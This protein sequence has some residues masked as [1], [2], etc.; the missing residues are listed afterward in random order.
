M[1]LLQNRRKQFEQLTSPLGHELFR[2]AYWRLANKDDAEDVVQETYLRAFRSFHT[3][4]IGSN[5]K[6]WMTRIL[7]N[8]ISDTMK[9]R[10]RLPDLIP[11]DDE[12]DQ[13]EALADP[14][15]M[16]QD[17]QAQLIERE[18]QPE[19]RQALQQLPTA[20]LHPLLLRELEDMSYSEIAAVLDIPAGTVMSRLF[21]ARK[22]LKDN[23]N[24]ITTA[25]QTAGEVLHDMC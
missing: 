21:R 7:L 2:I 24:R 19:L 25:N 8:V 18:I 15:A 14:S 20:L 13:I 6:A 12:Y 10:I 4:Q 1:K 11:I 16:A 5:I 17:P 9:K 3:F 22:V 23:L